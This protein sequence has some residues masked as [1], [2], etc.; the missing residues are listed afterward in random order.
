MVVASFHASHEQLPP[1]RLIQA[2]RAAEAAGFQGVTSSDHLAPWSERQGESG[3][4]WSWL[5]RRPR[6]DLDSDGR[7][8]RAR[9]S[10]ITRRSS[11]KRSR[12]SQRCTPVVCGWRSAPARPSTSMSPATRGPRRPTATGAC[13]N[14]WRSSAPSCRVRRYRIRVSSPWTAPASGA[15]RP[16]TSPLRRRG[17]R[18]DRRQG[19]RLGR[20]ADDA[21][22][23]HRAAP[24]RDRRVPRREVAA[25]PRLRAGPPLAGPQTE[26]EALEIAHEQWRTNVFGPE[27]AWNLELARTVR[28]GRSHRPPRRCPRVGLDLC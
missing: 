20:R 17:Q 28:R 21:P 13:S 14:A 23:T 15:F 10:G 12:R 6:G 16:P 24:A 11:L 27:I 1:S 22:S 26:A 4:A 3:F 5:G 2:V 9:A 18:G 7:R 19:G 8:H 25:K